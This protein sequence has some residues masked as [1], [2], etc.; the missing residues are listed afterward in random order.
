MADDRQTL[1]DGLAVGLIGFLSVAV[2]YAAF[3]FFASRG[4]LYTVDLLGKTVF[5]GWRDPSVVGLPIE[6]DMTSIAMYTVLHLMLS[7]AI[8]VFVVW[9]VS[10]AE[11]R[12]SMARMVLLTIIAGFVITIALVGLL[13][14]PIRPMLPWWSIVAANSIAVVMG[15]AY[16]LTKRPKTWRTL[17]TS[18]GSATG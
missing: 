2:L 15:G 10:Q 7:L 18:G 13:T 8:G 6:L 17:S 4:P 1:R 9:L 3:D 5:A 11:Q 14:E 16:L 12:P